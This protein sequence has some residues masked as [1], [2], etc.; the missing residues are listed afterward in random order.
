MTR[1]AEEEGRY[2]WYALT[3]PPSS[4]SAS[5]SNVMI[6]RRYD[7]AQHRVRRSSHQ[8]SGEHSVD[9][10]SVLI[11]ILNVALH[12]RPWLGKAI[13]RSTSRCVGFALTTV[14]SLG[15]ALLDEI[16][17]SV[18][19]SSLHQLANY[20]PRF[21]KPFTMPFW[22]FQQPSLRRSNLLVVCRLNSRY[23]QL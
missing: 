12:I 10:I 8:P 15:S 18:N 21:G 11:D 6:V 4:V 23:P 22:S 17:C 9:T 13:T 7:T 16:V 20:Y 14:V 19:V 2:S 5:L 1:D 3:S